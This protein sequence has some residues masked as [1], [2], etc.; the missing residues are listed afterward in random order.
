MVETTMEVAL[1]EQR[2]RDKIVSLRKERQLTQEAFDTEP[3][4]IPVRTIQRYE[5][6][7]NPNIELKTLIKIAAKLGVHPA[8]LLKVDLD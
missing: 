6:A 7:E 1:I 5:Q 4:A 8:E 2:V 3:D